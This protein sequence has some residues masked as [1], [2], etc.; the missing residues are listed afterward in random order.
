MTRNVQDLVYRTAEQK[1]ETFNILS[2]ACCP[3][4]DFSQL[5]TIYL[6]LTWLCMPEPH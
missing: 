2:L 1:I 4:F 3:N 6:G 5:R